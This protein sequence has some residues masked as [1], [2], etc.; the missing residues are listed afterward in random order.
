MEENETE[1]LDQDDEVS[2]DAPLD[3]GAEEETL[4]S[5]EVPSESEKPSEQIP[6][7]YVKKERLDKMMSSYQEALRDKRAADARVAQLERPVVQQK[8]SP[9]EKWLEYLDGKLRAR[10]ESQRTTEEQAAKKE[11]EEVSTLHPDLKRDDILNT[12]I[13]HNVN[14]STAAGFL[15][16]IGKAKTTSKTLTA[17]EIAR[18]KRAGRFGGKPSAIQPSGLTA[19]KRK[20][21]ESPME[22]IEREYEQGLKEL[23][24]EQ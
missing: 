9:E 4:E 13:R 2:E 24:I 5:E 3:E 22:A 20:K 6:E 8:E 7:G 12:A 17:N 1:E 18:K 19:Y 21:G 15:S 16:E 14:L 11:L 23:K 10:R